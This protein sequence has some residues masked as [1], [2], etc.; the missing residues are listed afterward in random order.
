MKRLKTA[1]K[2]PQEGFRG[3]DLSKVVLGS[4]SQPGV[5]AAQYLRPVFG[6]DLDNNDLAG[7]L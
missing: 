5:V 7:G 6:Q 4:V 1:L 2:P 3:K